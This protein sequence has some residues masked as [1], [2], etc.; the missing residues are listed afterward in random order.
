MEKESCLDSIQ[1]KINEATRVVLATHI[2]PDADAIGSSGSLCIALS[3]AGK[4]ARVYL[5]E[6]I[7]D[8]LGKLLSSEHVVHEC[9]KPGYLLIVVDCA[10]KKRLGDDADKL[11]DNADFVINIDH[12]ISNELWG[13]FNWVEGDTAATAIMIFNLIQSLSLPINSDVANLLYAGIMDDTGSFR[14][15][16]TSAVAL[17]SCASLLTYGANPS[18][19]ADLLYFREPLRV[20]QLRGKV[21]DTLKVTNSGRVATLWL[22]ESMRISAG[23]LPD[24]SEG[25]IDIA[26]AIDGVDVAL[27]I[28]EKSPG[29]WKASI[30]SKKITLDVSAFAARFGGGGHAAASGFSVDGTQEEVSK[31]IESHID[32]FIK[33]ECTTSA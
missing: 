18:F 2:S 14:Y 28:R 29:K 33:N 19:L 16:N 11:F 27:F 23:C 25:I 1:K 21:L 12:H 5:P 22:T 17:V 7:S 3:A 24:D 13:N 20:I 32:E 9:P 15:S 31:L 26:R 8:K 6:T 4:E 30:R 10:T